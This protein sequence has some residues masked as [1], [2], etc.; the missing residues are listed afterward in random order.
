[1]NI[2]LIKSWTLKIVPVVAAYLVGRGVISDEIAGQLPGVV[3]W[4]FVGMA[5]IPTLVRS[6]KNYG[7]RKPKDPI[8]LRPA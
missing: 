5:L 8:D 3:E 1:M 4:V 7:N 2:E 6:W